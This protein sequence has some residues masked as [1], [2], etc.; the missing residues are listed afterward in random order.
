MCV[1]MMC[2]WLGAGNE[3][4][5]KK[6]PDCLIGKTYEYVAKLCFTRYQLLFIAMDSY[7][8]DTGKHITYL[9]PFGC[10]LKNGMYGYFIAQN[11]ICVSDS[12]EQLSVE[13]LSTDNYVSMT[14]EQ[15][16][17]HVPPSSAEEQVSLVPQLNTSC[18]NRY[19]CYRCPERDFQSALVKKTSVKDHVILC[20]FTSHKLGRLSLHSFVSPLRACSITEHEL[21]PIVIIGNKD[22][23]Q[24][25]W[26]EIAN[27][28]QVYVIDGYP[29]DKGT[30]IAANVCH[31]SS[32]VILGSTAC[33]D[34]DPVLIDK[35]PIL[36]SLSLTSFN[37][38]CGEADNQIKSGKCI[39]KI[40]EIFR[41]ENVKFLDFNYKDSGS[42]FG[43]SHTFAQGECMSN[44]IF[45][46][47]MAVTYFNPGVTTL[48]EMLVTGEND[49]IMYGNC[50]LS[51]WPRFLQIS[52]QEEDYKR[53]EGLNFSELFDYLLEEKMLCIGISRV[54]ESQSS[55]SGHLKRYVI[56]SPHNL[57]L[58]P[59]DNIFVLISK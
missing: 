4:Y 20:T 2:M 58:K 55:S 14:A 40:T 41:E 28:D 38:D 30:L 54:M 48:F 13:F 51:C 23:I 22:C 8:Q 17:D 3:I 31:C 50:E 11:D 39:N 36:C 12:L 29:L 25:E 56:S 52:L 57:P 15:A 18:T 7:S 1:T 42:C 6:L 32:C 44:S 45:D 46:A 37:F 26:H 24:W 59:D 21:K 53:F 49:S 35:Q 47:L 27:F 19:L 5:R 9:P 34:N 43:T 10:T 33:L 16:L